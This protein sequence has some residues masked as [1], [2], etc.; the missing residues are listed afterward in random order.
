MYQAGVA[1]TDITAVVENI[2]MM[3]YGINTNIVK[4][5]ETPI[6]ARAYIIKSEQTGQKIAI[7]NAEICFISA[8]IRQ[9]V[10]RKLTKQYP[11][12]G[13][14]EHN[15]L[16]TAQ[17]TH[18]AAGGYEHFPFFVITIP[19][20]SYTVYNTYVDGIVEAIVKASHRLQ[21][22]TLR[23]H[24]GSFAPNPELAI[25]RSPQA[26]NQ[27]KDV[28]PIELSEPHL[29]TDLDMP[30][31]RIDDLEGKPIGMI[32]WFGV[33]TTSISNDNLLINADNKGY[34]AT[35]F[36]EFIKN[37]EGKK[38]F[39]AAFAQKSTGDITPNF[40]YDQGKKW[41]RG[42]FERDIESAAYH[43]KLQCDQAKE[44]FKNAVAQ[45]ALSGE[46]DYRL[47][48]V[49]FRHVSVDPDFANGQ[50]GKRTVPACIGVSFL[51]GTTEGPGVAP[52]ISKYILRPLTNVIKWA[53][54]VKCWLPIDQSEKE[55]IMVKYNFQHPK[56]IAI[57]TGDQRFLGI[58]KLT[59]IAAL[60]PPA[61]KDLKTIKYY[62]RAN[63]Q[64]TKPWT[65]QVLP[66]QIMAIGELAIVGIPGE[67]TIISGKR[68]EA[69]VRPAL[70][71]RG[72]KHI[73]IAPYANGYCGYITTNEEYQIQA[74][75]GGHTVFGQWTL[76]GFQTK[77][78]ELAQEIAD[79]P[80]Q[81]ERRIDLFPAEFTEKEVGTLL[82]ED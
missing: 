51:E 43:G 42:K 55:R 19:G 24:T 64:N 48:Y 30:L 44:I 1:K 77:L 36:E 31:L 81:Y 21:P 78:R 58:K 47:S 66:L 33:H 49:D 16:L 20:F 52:P 23:F 79:K 45:P 7:V 67:S 69:A 8:S 46:L 63:A 76:G 74:Y 75:E 26:Y 28:A 73:V 2:G 41:T 56:H 25:N 29:A 12:L 9:G 14:N 22:A 80:H 34:A 18:S 38:D 39:V 59:R 4:G 10:I 61:D 57:E 72:V 17:H 13:F 40:F 68:I 71:K 32:N 35:Y 5:V 60:L 6:H 15:V 53:E 37:K 27:N 54:A 50:T 11:E 65:P 82:F 3:G 62:A 70:Q